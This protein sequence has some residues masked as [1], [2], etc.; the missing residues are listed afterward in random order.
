M[1]VLQYYRAMYSVQFIRNTARIIDKQVGLHRAGI[2]VQ[3]VTSNEDLIYSKRVLQIKML[4][5]RNLKH[6]ATKA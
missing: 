4:K 3:P 6:L 1:H 5:I 2:L